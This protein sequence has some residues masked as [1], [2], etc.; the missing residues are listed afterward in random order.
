MVS[1][2]G[3]QQDIQIRGGAIDND[4][5]NDA[6]AAGHVSASYAPKYFLNIAHR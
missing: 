6:T 2:I 3:E 5:D 4:N 1:Q